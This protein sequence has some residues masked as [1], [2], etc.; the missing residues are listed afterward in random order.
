MI[1]S[2]KYK[3]FTELKDSV[4]RSSISESRIVDITNDLDDFVKKIISSKGNIKTT[5]A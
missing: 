2:K 3:T 4:E 1:K 5:G